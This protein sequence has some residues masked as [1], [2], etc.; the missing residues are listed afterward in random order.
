[1]GIQTCV[2]SLLY[3]YHGQTVSPMMVKNQAAEERVIP[4]PLSPDVFELPACPP[5]DCFL[6]NLVTSRNSLDN[7]LVDTPAMFDSD[8]KVKEMI[9]AQN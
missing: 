5:S 7:I 6:Y 4:S 8:D 2:S 1:M 9:P 3:R